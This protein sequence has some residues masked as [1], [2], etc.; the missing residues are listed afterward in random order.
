MHNLVRLF[1]WNISLNFSKSATTYGLSTIFLMYQKFRNISEVPLTYSVCWL[2]IL[3]IVGFVVNS[4]SSH[5]SLKSWLW[6][7][8]SINFER[9]SHIFWSLKT[10]ENQIN[11]S[12]ANVHWFDLTTTLIV[13]IISRSI[14]RLVV[15]GKSHTGS[16]DGRRG[17]GRLVSSFND[18][19]KRNYNCSGAGKL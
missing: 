3:G 9:K 6:D 10:F 7:V 5:I 4:W 8:F 18:D 15:L 19:L 11:T 2:Y 17:G 16:M 1:T 14:T 12:S 13:Q